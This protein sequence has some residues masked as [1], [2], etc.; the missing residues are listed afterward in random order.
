MAEAQE[1]G[2]MENPSAQYPPKMYGHSMYYRV[3]MDEKGR[4]MEV[5]YLAG[6]TTGN[7][8]GRIKTEVGM[9]NSK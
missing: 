9:Q 1:G 6:G 8:E 3:E 7:N 5:V 4:Q 2:N